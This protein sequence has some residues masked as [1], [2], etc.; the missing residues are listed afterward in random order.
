MG[1]VEFRWATTVEQVLACLLGPMVSGLSAH[2]RL[3]ALPLLNSWGDDYP[4]TVWVP[5]A[6]MQ[7]L[8]DEQGDAAVVTDRVGV[9][10]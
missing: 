6:A 8:L 10:S 4:R 7:R 1:I 5:F 2:E 3:Q 9:A